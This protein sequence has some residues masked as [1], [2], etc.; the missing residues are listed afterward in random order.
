MILLSIL[1]TCARLFASIFSNRVKYIHIIIYCD[2]CERALANSYVCLLTYTF[3]T[4][5]HRTHV[6]N[7]YTTCAVDCCWISCRFA[8]LPFAV[9]VCVS[10]FAFYICSLS[11]L[12]ICRFPVHI[13]FLDNLFSFLFASSTD[14]KHSY[15]YNVSIYLSIYI[16]YIVCVSLSLCVSAYKI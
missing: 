5:T 8:F 15:I 12:I 2:V 11:L 1:L 7:H 16:Y 3:T 9:C 10:L 6:H 4:C 14:N 13:S